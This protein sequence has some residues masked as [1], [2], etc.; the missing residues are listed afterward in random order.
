MR[1]LYGYLATRTEAEAMQILSLIRA[2]PDD[3][4]AV[5]RAIQEADLLLR[6]AA[7]PR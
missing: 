6:R 5:L 4:F 7:G 1:E 3:P 2:H